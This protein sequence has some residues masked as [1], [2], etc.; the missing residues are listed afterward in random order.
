[1]R[2]D[3]LESRRT[4]RPQLQAVVVCALTQLFEEDLAALLGERLEFFEL[5]IEL[6][7]RQLVVP[8]AL[9]R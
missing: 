3:P 8:P 5:E 7:G 1:M 4:S 2:D 9:C 6:G